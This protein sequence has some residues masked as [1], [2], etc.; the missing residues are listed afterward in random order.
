MVEIAVCFPVFM[1]ILLGIIE[2]GRAMSVGQMLNAAARE[3]CRSAVI[4][5][6]T[7]DN[8]TAQIK[9]HVVSMIGCSDNDVAV[10][11]TATSKDTGSTLADLSAA[12]NR[13]LIEVDV[14]V[15]YSAVSFA[16]NNFLEGKLL[17]GECSMRHE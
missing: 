10:A 4:D 5:G 16:V 8:V 6:S 13:D 11:I 17:R 15:P 2:F 12:G 3:G 14:S 7:T 9:E 1:L